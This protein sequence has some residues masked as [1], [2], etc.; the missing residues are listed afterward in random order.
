[1]TLSP[2]NRLRIRVVDDS[3]R[4]VN[5][6]RVSLQAWR[7]FNTLGWNGTSAEDGSLEWNSAPPDEMNLC[8]YANGYCY[9]RDNFI[10][11][12][13]QE[14]VITLH[15]QFTVSGLVNDSKTGRPVS[16]FK[17]MP[18]DQRIDLVDASNGVYELKMT[19]YSPSLRLQFEAEGYNATDS[20]P[21]KPTGSNVVCNISLHRTAPRDYVQGIVLLPDGTPAAGV[22]VGLCVPGRFTTIGPGRFVNAPHGLVVKTDGDGEFSFPHVS[23]P[24]IV[25]A[26]SEK[27]FGRAILGQ[28]N[29]AVSILLKPWGRPEGQLKLSHESS[30]DRKVGITGGGRPG[31]LGLEFYAQSDAQG[32]FVIDPAPTLPCKLYVYPIGGV[33]TLRHETLVEIHPGSTV[34]VQIGGIGCSLAGHFILEKPTSSIDWSRQLLFPDL[35]TQYAMP[36]RVPKGYWDSEEGIARSMVVRHCTVDVNPDGSFK[37]DEVLPGTYILTGNLSSIAV[38][39]TVPSGIG[40]AMNDLIG[41]INRSV[42]VPEGEP[43]GATLDVGNVP[44]K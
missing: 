44:V 30:N 20:P 26:V 2:G 37:I 5:R 35:A 4:P 27:G 9:T 6:A 43:A 22:E 32:R 21:L 29:L 18:Q 7:G 39:P 8:A 42:T 23:D 16:S 13:G 1:V 38:D 36:Q 28:T 40:A 41:R 24:R 12:D 3:N 11:A 17:V 33:G 19:E 15:R 10:A 34:K 25:A 31:S 14:H